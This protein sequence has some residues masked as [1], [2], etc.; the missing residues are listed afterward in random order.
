MARGMKT[1]RNRL[2]A[3]IDRGQARLKKAEEDIR[4]LS[5]GR[6][7]ELLKLSAASRFEHLDDPDLTQSD[8]STL[9]K[10]ISSTLPPAKRRL[11]VAFGRLRPIRIGRWIR[12]RGVAL[13]IS[14]IIGLPL[15]GF[16]ALAWSN[17]GELV[18]VRQEG[19]LTWQ[20]PSGIAE[21]GG[22]RAGD[23]LII[24]RSLWSTSA[25]RWILGKGYATAPVH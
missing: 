16:A 5:E 13:I 8:R 1:P 11:S 10:S 19:I 22:V 18:D 2:D 12:Q 20:T 15:C 23:S 24:S 14:S 9:R 17:T 4:L 6:L 7:A 21:L 25:R 3:R